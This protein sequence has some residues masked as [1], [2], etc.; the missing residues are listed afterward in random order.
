MISGNAD[1][2][3]QTN[4]AVPRRGRDI[5]RDLISISALVLSL[6]QAPSARAD[7]TSCLAK[8]SAYVVELD[9]LLSKERNWITPYFNL[10]ERTFPIRDCEADALLEVVRGSHFIRSISYSSRLNEY[11]IIF[12]S[13]DVEADIAYHVSVIGRCNEAMC[14]EIFRSG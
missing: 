10:I 4:T 5:A 9:T 12:S 7:S 2:S 13:D 6:T 11:F 1:H 8:V 3:T 14:L